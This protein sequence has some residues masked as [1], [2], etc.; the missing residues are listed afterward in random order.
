MNVTEI[1][2]KAWPVMPVIVIDE[3]KHALPMAEALREGGVT[4]LEITLRTDAA[5][6]AISAIAKAL[7][8]VVVGAGTV[9]TGEQLQRVKDAGAAFAV[10]P[11]LTEKLLLAADRI[12]L[13]LLPGAVTASEIQLALE[14]GLQ[15]LKFFPAE[16]AGGAPVIKAFHGPFSQLRFC[17]TGGISTSNATQ[18]LSL[19]NVACVGGSW[20]TPAAEMKAGNW[21]ALTALAR[22]SRLLS[23]S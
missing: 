3:P 6:T 18:Y 17:P 20:L 2:A 14:Y 4:V 8:D 23:A 12:K 7:P 11:G 16:A 15:T 21:S 9:L 19:P 22:A 10:S 1:L 13:P 5:F